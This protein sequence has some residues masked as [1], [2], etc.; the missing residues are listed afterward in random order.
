[1]KHRYK[2]PYEAPIYDC[3]KICGQCTEYRGGGCTA[4]GCYSVTYEFSNPQDRPIPPPLNCLWWYANRNWDKV[5]EQKVAE[6]KEERLHKF[7]ESEMLRRLP[8]HESR[9]ALIHHVHR[10]NGGRLIDFEKYPAAQTLYE[11]FKTADDGE[12]Q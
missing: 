4:N 12:L 5:P 8:T 9:N 7:V 11:F 6:F 1:M 2:S 3:P 10:P